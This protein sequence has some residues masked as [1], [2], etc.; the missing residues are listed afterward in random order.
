M[1]RSPVREDGAPREGAHDSK[2]TQPA[3]S[4]EPPGSS[5]QRPPSASA[6]ALNP[7]S[8]L[9]SPSLASPASPSR[10]PSSAPPSAPESKGAESKGA[11]VSLPASN[12]NNHAS[13]R[14]AS[15][16]GN[17]HGLEAGSVLGVSNGGNGSQGSS[18]QGGSSQ[19]S[20]SQGGN[21]S[22]GGN[23]SHGGNGSNGLVLSGQTA[24]GN[25][26]EDAAGLGLLDGA[27]PLG[28]PT[29][30]V[31]RGRW[32][33]AANRT[34]GLEDRL[35]AFEDI[36]DSEVGD[37]TLSRARNL[38]REFGL[39][40]IYLKFEGVNPTGSQKDRIAFAQVMDA[41]RRGYEGVTVATCG[42]YG[43][44]LSLAASMAGLRCSIFIPESYH[45]RR[46]DEMR[47]HG[48]EIVRAGP[49]YESAVAASRARAERDE[50]YDANPGGAN[51]PLQLLAYGGIAYEIYDDLRDAPA[52]V[53]CPV[54]NGTTLAGVWKGFLSLYR[55]GKT[56]R[57]PRMVAGSSYGKN[58]IVHA[59]LKSL[60]RC[61]D[62]AQQKVRETATNEPLINSHAFDGEHTLAAIRST[63]GWASYASD[64]NLSVLSRTLRDREGLHVLPASTAGLFALLEAHRKSALPS[65]RYVVILTGRRS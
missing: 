60:P 44:A 34:R 25:G 47:S 59:F 35:A 6:R 7:P 24:V 51:A 56:A 39:R 38:E 21:G 27:A 45:T 53:A 22:R 58:P 20:S 11:P 57:M 31:I 61:E 42:N 46:I 43:A 3:D 9:L 18:S 40:Q 15:H 41:L 16:G 29:D 37:T 4:G 26:E 64:K 10:P 13:S 48:A 54:S 33:A 23:G 49:D 19:G 32:A 36:I 2:E 17:G 8:A 5:P 30:T 63:G 62:I 52:A 28:L 14:H 50:L 55:R 65:D 1:T 12:D